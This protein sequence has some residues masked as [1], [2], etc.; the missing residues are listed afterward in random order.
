M[1][2]PVLELTKREYDEAVG[3]CEGACME[4]G[5]TCCD[6]SSPDARRERCRCG[7]MKVWGMRALLDLGELEIVNKDED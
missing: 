1:P 7:A 6:V 2:W 4:C 3:D 5:D